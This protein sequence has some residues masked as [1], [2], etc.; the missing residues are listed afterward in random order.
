MQMLSWF[1]SLVIFGLFLAPPSESERGQF[2]MITL[3][4]PDSVSG[5]K[6]SN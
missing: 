3:L 4:C 6:F 2:G 5:A 1:C